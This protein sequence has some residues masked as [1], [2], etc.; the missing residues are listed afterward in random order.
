MIRYSH[1]WALGWNVVATVAA[2][3]AASACMHGSDSGSAQRPWFSHRSHLESGAECEDCHEPLEQGDGVGYPSYEM[4]MDCH[5]DI[6]GEKPPERRAKIF[7]PQDVASFKHVA[8]LGAEVIFSHNAHIE[9]GVSC[10]ECHAGIE[11]SEAVS[12]ELA[13]AMRRCM[14][15]H[16]QGQGAALSDPLAARKLG[17]NECSTC[18]REIRRDR[19]P[20]SHRAGFLRSHGQLAALRR[21]DPLPAECAICHRDRSSCDGCHSDMAPQSH[22][23]FWRLRGHAL[24][25]AV[26]R[27]SCKVCHR[28]SDFCLRCHEEV[29]PRDH[30]GSFDAPL[31]RHCLSCHL[32]LGASRCRTCHQG[33]P[34]H[35]QAPQVPGNAQHM[36]NNPADC[37]NCHTPMQHVYNGDNCLL[38]HRR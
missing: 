20:P 34:G 35:D 3:M 16:S 18:H 17:A 30:L 8:R 27:E 1:R 37:L 24:M 29:P 5:A 15:C 22:T 19:K 25:S 14:D 28:T 12:A 32:P 4:C 11:E 36:T 6:D 10:A 7:F 13:V 38:C 33:T 2:A 31:N 21:L 26:D 9:Y 23:N